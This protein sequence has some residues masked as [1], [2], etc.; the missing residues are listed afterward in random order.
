MSAADSSDDG[1]T[2]IDTL[3]NAEETREAIEE[4]REEKVSEHETLEE[5]D[6]TRESLEE[7]QG[8]ENLGPI[9]EAVNEILN[10]HDEHIPPTDD[11]TRG[12]CVIGESVEEADNMKAA[13]PNTIGDIALEERVTEFA[14]ER[15]SSVR[16][17]RLLA[18]TLALW[19]EDDD[20]DEL[21]LARNYT[22]GELGVLLRELRL[23]GSLQRE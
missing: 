23:G 18:G 19:I 10:E 15:M 11:I 4:F 5:L 9:Q 14:T 3:S 20:I 8:D 1:A 16:T 12:S 7:P 13:R 17:A 2:G 6:E 22:Q 21:H